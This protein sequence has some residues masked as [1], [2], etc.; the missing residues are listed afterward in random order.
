MVF[1][2]A[3]ARAPRC[4]K[5]IAGDRFGGR[6]VAIG[7]PS[8]PNRPHRAVPDTGRG[9]V[10][11]QKVKGGP[12]L[13]IVV[14]MTVIRVTCGACGDVELTAEEMRV[15]RC[16][17]TG[18]ATYVF[19]CPDCHMAEVRTAEEHV[20]EVLRSAGVVCAEWQLP[21]ELG[22]RPIGPPLTHDDLLDFHELLATPDWFDAVRPLTR[23]TEADH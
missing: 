6:R 5:R 8:C 10:A 1:S 2:G 21:A 15:R 18:A 12:H 22:E 4:A 7:R 11:D 14:V 16:V 19:I 9:R 3:L 23:P 17:E 20:V 13:P